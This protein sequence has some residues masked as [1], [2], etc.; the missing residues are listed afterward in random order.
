M[1]KRVACIVTMLFLLLYLSATTAAYGEEVVAGSSY[2]FDGVVNAGLDTGYS[3]AASIK[4]DDPHFGWK[5]GKFVLSGFTSWRDEKTPVLLK[6]VGDQVKLSYVLEQDIDR[7]DG[8]EEI[9]ICDDKDGYDE[10]FGIGKTKE[11]MGRGTLIVRHTDY[12]NSTG[13]PQ[14]YTNYLPALVVGAETKVDLLEEG[15]YEVALD[16]EVAS[17]GA[18][19]IRPTYNNYRSYFKFKVRNGNVMFFLLD[20]ES[21]DELYNGSVTKSGFRIDTGGSHYLDINV[22]REILNDTGD[23]LVEDTRF[24]RTATDGSTF[25]DEGIYTISASSSGSN[26]A[27]TEKRVYVGDDDVLKATVANQMNVADVK[28][29]MANGATVA[30]DGTLVRAS[31]DLPGGRVVSADEGDTGEP[32]VGSRNPI[33]TIAIATVALVGFTVIGKRRKTKSNKEETEEK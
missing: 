9:T 27:P 4:N 5:L 21:G 19:P 18:L 29:E 15:D 23:E 12:R 30:E 1:L 14:I 20:N 28:S 24:N 11:G 8:N 32:K 13:D 33:L 22:R 31:L 2:E 16:Y 6:N 10:Y 26:A 25:E 7:L 3:R 17:P